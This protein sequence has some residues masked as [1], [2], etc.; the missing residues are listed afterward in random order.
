MKKISIKKIDF[1]NVVKMWEKADD[2]IENG[3]M[4]AEHLPSVLV[5]FQFGGRRPLDFPKSPYQETEVMYKPS[6]VE[7]LGAYYGLYFCVEK[8]QEIFPKKCNES[9]M[10]QINAALTSM[11]GDNIS[12][13][14]LDKE[15]NRIKKSIS[16]VHDEI[17]IPLLLRGFDCGRCVFSLFNKEFLSKT[18]FRVIKRIANQLFNDSKQDCINFY[19]A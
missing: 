10:I 17:E 12:L 19:K 16:S 14:Q 6:L 13:I 3:Y 1:W 7:E 11:Y 9:T 8:L 2:S 15:I 18:P 5:Y 4:S